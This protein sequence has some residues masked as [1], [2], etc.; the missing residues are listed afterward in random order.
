MQMYTCRYGYSVLITVLSRASAHG[1]SQLKYQKLRVGGYME[2]VLKWFNYPHARAH[3][4]CG[5]RCQG[6]PHCHFVCASSRPARQ[7][8]KQ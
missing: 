5:V 1:R 7:C 4:R 2:E 6:I 3:P 8:R